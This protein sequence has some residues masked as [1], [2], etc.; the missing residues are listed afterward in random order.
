MSRFG[1]LLL[2]ATALAAGAAALAWAWQGWTQPALLL[3]LLSGFW[4]CG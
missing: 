4:L 2:L 3:Q 1:K